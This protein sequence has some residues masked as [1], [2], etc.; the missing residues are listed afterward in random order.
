MIRP[1]ILPKFRSN[2]SVEQ[3]IVET[4]VINRM[5]KKKPIL[6]YTEEKQEIKQVRLA[7]PFI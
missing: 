1:I 2:A 3:L 4:W 6:E 5:G 7:F